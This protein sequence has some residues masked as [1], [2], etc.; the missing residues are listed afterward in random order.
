M[1]KYNLRIVFKKMCVILVTS[2]SC[3]NDMFTQK[4]N[5]IVGHTKVET[6][7]RNKMEG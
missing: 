7:R 2:L 3:E 4:G 6:I 5:V 1:K